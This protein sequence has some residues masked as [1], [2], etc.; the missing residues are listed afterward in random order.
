MAP[1]AI[2]V[3]VPT[4]NRLDFLSRCLAA[5]APGAQ[6]LP[7]EQ[8]EVIVTDDGA[9]DDAKILVATD[10]AWAKW[11]RG[12]RRGPAANRNSGAQYAS[13]TWLAFTDDDCVPSDG[14]LQAYASAL[15]DTHRVFEGRTI[16]SDWIESPL[17]EAPININGGYL[18]S[19]NMLI[20][21][22]FFESLG[23]FDEDYPYPAMEDVDLRERIREGG[24]EFPF[25]PTAI[26]DHP[27]RLRAGGRVKGRYKECEFLFAV[28]HKRPLGLWSTFLV[29]LLFH[30]AR[31]W[32]RSKVPLHVF[33]SAWNAVVEGVYVTT[34]YAGW[35]RKYSP[36]R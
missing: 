28:K 12:Q 25:V 11:N 24:Q 9:D 21:R 22:D 26:V 18:W 14:W 34:H 35:R 10:F 20:E 17:Y 19:C 8:Y 5:L 30:H 3:I 4:C 27:K 15:D 29:P 6:T 2:T 32:K 36:R 31:M 23:G 7:P 1:P 33:P 16:C 13:G